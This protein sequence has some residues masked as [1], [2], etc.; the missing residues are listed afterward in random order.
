MAMVGQ[1]AAIAM[2]MMGWARPKPA[3][4]GWAR[5]CSCDDHDGV[6]YAQ[7][8]WQWLGWARDQSYKTSSLHRTLSDFTFLLTCSPN[9]RTNNELTVVAKGRGNS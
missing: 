4:N 8:C 7:T 1:G 5:R 6:S 3:G 9:F 2:I